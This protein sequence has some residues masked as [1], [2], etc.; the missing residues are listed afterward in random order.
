MLV[1]LA[2]IQALKQPSKIVKGTKRMPAWD[3]LQGSD[4]GNACGKP[5]AIATPSMHCQPILSDA[6]ASFSD[7]LIMW[8]NLAVPSQHGS[9]CS[10]AIHSHNLLCQLQLPLHPFS[11]FQVW[12]PRP[13]EPCF[14]ASKHRTS[15][16]CPCSSH[17]IVAHA[18]HTTYCSLAHRSAQFRHA[19]LTGRHKVSVS[20]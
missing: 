10:V 18:D 14:A 20:H 13:D 1:S 16:S 17:D 8:P 6:R 5:T 9:V 3:S 7:K 12:P 4:N 15:A 2:V 19:Y 11:S